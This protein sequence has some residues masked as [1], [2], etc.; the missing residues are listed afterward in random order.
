MMTSFHFRLPNNSLAWDGDHIKYHLRVEKQPGTIAV[1]FT[2]RIHFPNGVI[3][4]SA[5]PRGTMAGNSL[6]INTELREDLNINIEFLL[7]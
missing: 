6:I 2:I 4:K 1:P 3:I 7:Q 5:F